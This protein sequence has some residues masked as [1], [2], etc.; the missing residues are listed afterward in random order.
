[1]KAPTDSFAGTSSP[2]RTARSASNL[3]GGKNKKMTLQEQKAREAEMKRRSNAEKNLNAWFKEIK[4][5]LEKDEE[6]DFN[7]SLK[8]KVKF[9]KAKDEVNK[10]IHYLCTESLQYDRTFTS[11]RNITKDQF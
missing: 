10:L 9:C 5:N 1:M 3:K 6:A 7:T 11:D 8:I 2:K 4:T